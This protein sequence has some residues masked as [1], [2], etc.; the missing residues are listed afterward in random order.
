LRIV[1]P[2]TLS[3]KERELFEALKDASNFD[4]RRT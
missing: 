1:V 4:P 3:E 2:K